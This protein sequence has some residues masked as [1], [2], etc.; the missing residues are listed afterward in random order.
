MGSDQPLLP[1]KPPAQPQPPPGAGA[2]SAAGSPPGAGDDR[3][4]GRAAIAR[5]WLTEARLTEAVERQRAEL[6]AGRPQRLLGTI[7]V[8][9]R[10]LAPAQL[11]TLLDQQARASLTQEDKLYGATLVRDGLATRAAVDRALAD[12][13]AAPSPAP[14]PAAPAALFAGRY[15]ILRAL[16]RGGMGVVYRARDAQLGREVALKLLLFGAGAGREE[17]ERFHREARAAGALDHPGIVRVL[18]VGEADGKPYYTMELVEGRGLAVIARDDVLPLRDAVEIVRQLADAL[19]YAHAHGVLH[20]DI[21]PANAVILRDGDC[22]EAV[23]T[24]KLLDFGLAKLAEREVQMRS[25]D[26]KSASLRTLTRTGAMMGTPAYMSP[27][28]VRASADVDGRTD[29]Y[30]LGATFYEILTGRPP[31]HEAA[32]LASLLYQ[33]EGTDPTPPSRFVP[34]VDRDVETICLKCLQKSP[35]ER[36]ATARDLARDCRR[37]LAGEPIA[38]RPVGAAARLWK[39][40]KRNKPVAIPV[41]ALGLLLVGAAAWA[42]VGALVHARD[43]AAYRGAIE[44]G[45]REGRAGDVEKTTALLR[46]LEPNDKLVIDLCNQVKAALAV[47]RGD[48]SLQNY[49]YLR[50]RLDELRSELETEEKKAQ[51]AKRHAEKDRLWRLDEDVRV[52]EQ[53]RERAFADAVAAYSEAVGWWRESPSARER[54]GDLYW[55]KYLDA[56][57]RRSATDQATYGGLVV[58]FAREKYADAL[59]CAKEVELDFLLPA[60]DSGRAAGGAPPARLEAWLFRY[61]RN[62]TPPVL[63]PV[64]CDPATGELKGAPDLAAAEPVP[65]ATAAKPEGAAFVRA[66]RRESVFALRRTPANRVLLEPAPATPPAPGATADPDAGR[67]RVRFH[68]TLPR[69]SYLLLLPAGQGVYETRY[70]FEVAR[71]LEWKETCELAPEAEVPPLPPGMEPP[72]VEA[73]GQAPG[74]A[75]T[76]ARG[77]WL[78]LPA[79]PF[80]ASG[81]P[82]AQQSP[83][84]DAAVLRAPPPTPSAPHAGALLARFELTCGM[85][86][87]YLNDRDWHKAEAAFLRAPRKAPVATPETVYWKLGENGLLTSSFSPDWPILEVSWQDAIDYAKWLTARVGGGRWTLSLP[88][89][90]EWEKAARGAD[91]RYFPWG[92]AFDA[93]FCSMNDSRLAEQESRNPEPFGLFL[94]DESPFGVR[95]LAGGMREWTRTVSGRKG[96]YRIAKGGCWSGP[97]ALCRGADRLASEPEYVS[98]HYGFRL[99][100]RRTR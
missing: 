94:V 84:R 7:L 16:G 46:A 56:E 65:L 14:V 59:R 67:P 51:A 54:L 85:Y 37:W 13:A 80:R 69:G 57:R 26:E 9:L 48:E 60:P 75:A 92:D 36:Y 58:S 79:G 87:V 64:P 39:R 96:E 20:R 95:D 28:Q 74:A 24:A 55:D 41:A 11:L 90:D 83:P 22:D 53:D 32:T 81:D 82:S 99:S 6:E 31:F 10:A 77:Y 35:S 98:V 62:R 45:L 66:S 76:A 5:G 43:V 44:A 61:E 70:P 71:D 33:I 91:G 27:E 3:R 89:E 63:V 52:M 4:L 23:L 19:Q 78:Y 73:G 42:G 38:A 40:A 2:D 8:E 18:D 34:D 12:Q 93:S 97:S 21:K 30:S 15:Q 47:G 49:V 100:A 68:A 86:L 72:P 50:G 25:T 29:V 88:S 1:G 17:V